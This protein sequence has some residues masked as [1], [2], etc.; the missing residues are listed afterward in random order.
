MISAT[1]DKVGITVITSDGDLGAPH[2]IKSNDA[3]RSPYARVVT[4][5]GTARVVGALIAL[6]R[7]SPSHLYVNSLFD[8]TYSLIPVLI[9]R[10][11]I[12]GAQVVIAPRGE[13]G[14]GALAIRAKKKKMA[15][16]LLRHLPIYKRAIWH[17]TDE[18]EAQNIQ[19]IIRE[20]RILQVMNNSQIAGPEHR[21][22]ARAPN[23]LLFVG[24]I[25]PKKGLDIALIALSRVSQPAEIVVAGGHS[26]SEQGYYQRCLELASALP[27]HIRAHFMGPIPHAEVVEEMAMAAALILPTADENFGHVIAEALA[28]GCP[29][30]IPPTTPWTSEAARLGTL[31][32]DRDPETWVAAIEAYLNL[33]EDRAESLRDLSLEL[34]AAWRQSHDEDLTLI[35]LLRCRPV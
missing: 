5:G 34:F 9:S 16:A 27:P 7:A 30:M 11:I 24:R 19:E 12:P 21:A 35:D 18:K 23:R 33:P 15:I 3:A 13:L 10:W 29:V 28:N 25:S 6:R 31:V 1:L 32:K 4:C 2:S 14:E 26:P 20:A 17:A 22:P 8:F